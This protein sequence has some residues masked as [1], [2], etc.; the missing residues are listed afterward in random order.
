MQHWKTTW[1]FL[2]RLGISV[3]I[4]SGT[5]FLLI[6]VVMLEGEG[7]CQLQLFCGLVYGLQLLALILAQV[8][9]TY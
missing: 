1:I 7:S 2:L 5:V 6:A 3:P 8:L 4:T 9:I